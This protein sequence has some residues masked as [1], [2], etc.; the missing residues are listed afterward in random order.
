MAWTNWSRENA[1]CEHKRRAGPKNVFFHDFLLISGADGSL[2]RVPQ[3]S[4]TLLTLGVLR[5]HDHLA[6]D[7]GNALSSCKR[8][9]NSQ[10][11]LQTIGKELDTISQAA[12][13]GTHE[14]AAGERT[15]EHPRQDIFQHRCRGQPYRQP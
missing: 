12:V 6:V 10:F 15:L 5:N 1:G 13:S 2:R 9:G 3:R 11:A 8:H 7:V 4:A 14:V